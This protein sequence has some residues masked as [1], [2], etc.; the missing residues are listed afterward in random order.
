MKVAGLQKEAELRH[1]VV[2]EDTP[3]PLQTTI[4]QYRVWTGLQL[5]SYVASG[6]A[7]STASKR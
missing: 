2:T 7:M 3:Y 6:L 5:I 1:G 4:V